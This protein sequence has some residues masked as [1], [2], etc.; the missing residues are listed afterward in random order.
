MTKMG[1]DLMKSLFSAG[2][3]ESRQKKKDGMVTGA[4]VTHFTHCNWSICIGLWKPLFGIGLWLCEEAIWTCFIA[5][6]EFPYI[7]QDQEA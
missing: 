1:P 4:A 3:V 6:L 5:T 7:Q 2:F